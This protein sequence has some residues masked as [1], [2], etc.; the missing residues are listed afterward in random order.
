MVRAPTLC[1]SG[2]APVLA[3]IAVTASGDPNVSES[4]NAAVKKN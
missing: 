3:A 4:S 1:Y 2:G